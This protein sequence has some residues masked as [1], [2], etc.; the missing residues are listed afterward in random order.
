MNTSTQTFTLINEASGSPLIE[1]TFEYFLKFKH[2]H[3][4]RETA[5]NWDVV[6]GGHGSIKGNILGIP[7][8]FEDIHTTQ[9]TNT[10][11]LPRFG[12]L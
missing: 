1:K 11:T 10:N 6:I 7:I 9:N 8:P 4:H 5:T 3:T 12:V 2:T